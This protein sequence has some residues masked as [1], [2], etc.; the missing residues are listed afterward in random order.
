MKRKFIFLLTMM[1]LTLLG[2]AKWNV[3][4]AQS[5][6]VEIGENSSTTNANIPFNTYYYASI[7]QQIYLSNQINGAG[8]IADV[9]F[10]RFSGTNQAREIEVYMVNTSKTQFDHSSDWVAVTESDRV[11]NG[12]LPYNGTA[13]GWYTITLDNPFEYTGE[14]LLIC[15][16]LKN[17]SKWDYTNYHYTID[18][19]NTLA[20][21]KYAD[22]ST[23]NPSNMT[24]SGTLLN[25][26]NQVRF[27]IEPSNDDLEPA[28][29][30]NLVATAKNHTSI[31]LAWDA[32]ENVKSYN[33]YQDGVKLANVTSTYYLVEGL[34]EK[35]DYCFT[36]TGVR[37]S[38]ESDASGEA[39]AK[40]NAA[41]LLR[42]VIVG[43][44]EGTCNFI[45]THTYYKYAITQQI[46][47]A[48]ELGFAAG[49]ISK[50]AFKNV[51]SFYTARNIDV[52]IV[53]TTKDSFVDKNDVVQMTDADLV[54]SGTH[55]FGLG[56]S[57][58]VFSKNFEYTGGNILI[59]VDDNTGN[60]PGT[61]QFAT[62]THSNSNNRT[63][64][65]YNDGGNYD[66][67]TITSLTYAEPQ[68]NQIK[69]FVESQPSLNVNVDKIE[70]P[71]VRLG[72]YWTGK[73]TNMDVEVRTEAIG[74]EVIDIETTNNYFVLS[75]IDLSS[76]PIIFNVSCSTDK[77]YEGEQNGN[78]IISY[79]YEGDSE[80]LTKEI[81]MS[82]TAYAPATP[83]VY[84]LAQEVT[85]TN[86]SYTNTPNFA[87]LHDDYILPGEVTEGN[88]LDAVY[89]FTMENEGALTVNV[90]GTN[91]I[92]AIY[93]AEDLQTNGPSFNNNYEGTEV[94]V[95]PSAPTSF[96][97][98]FEDGSLED[99]N[100][101]EYDGN[102]NHW[103][104]TTSNGINCIVSYSYLYQAGGNIM[105]ADNYIYTKEKYA[106]T[107]NSKLSFDTKILST[108]YPDKVM[109]K[110]STDGEVFTLIETI[111]PMSLEWVSKTVDLGAK[112][113]ELGLAYGEYHIALHHQDY[114]QERIYIDNLR[115][116]D[117]SA[118]NRGAQIDAV[119]YPAG[120]YYLVAAAEDEF[121]VS[122]STEALP[123]PEALTEMTP[124]NGATEQDNPK[125]TWSFGKYTSEYQV[126]L[127]TTNP[128]TEVVVDWT[129]E[130]ATS[131]QTEGLANQTIYYWQV[132]TRNTIGTTTGEVYSFSTPLNKATELAVTDAELY[133]GETTTLT[134]TAA[135]SA[136]SYNVYVNE[137]LFAEAIE[138][139]SF[140]LTNLPHNVNPGNAITVTAVHTLGESAHSEAV[141][142]KMAGT[143]N[144]VVNVKD[145]EGNV[146]ENAAVAFNTINYYDEYY[147][148]VPAID[149]LYTD[150]DGKATQT[151]A[152][153]CE[154][155][156]PNWTYA[157]LAVNISKEYANV[158]YFYIN[159]NEV[160]NG[161]VYV[162]DITLE[163]VGP[164]YVE[165]DKGIYVAGE[166]MMVLTWNKV[167]G[168]IAYNIYKQG[169]YSYETYEYEYTLI[170]TETITDT[171]FTV[172]SL[173][174]VP[175]SY[176]A[177]Y[178]VSA[179]YSFGE[180]AKTDKWVEITGKGLISGTV[181]DG[182]N[183]IEGAVVAIS[184]Y[185]EYSGVSRNYTTTTA[186]DG[187]Y[188]IN[189]LV[190]EYDLTV[191]RYD[192][193]DYSYSGIES[194]YGTPTVLDIVLEQ[195]AVVEF[196][197]T[198]V[199]SGEYVNVS[200]T[201]PENA[202]SYK[203]YR[204]DSEGNVTRIYSDVTSLTATDYNWSTLENGTYEY[205]VSA[206]IEV[207]KS[208]TEGFENGGN[209]PDGWTTYHTGT[210]STFDWT[211]TT[212]A[213]NVSPTEGSY[214]VY[215]NNTNGSGSSTYG[216]FYLVAPLYDL[217]GIENPVVSFY[218]H[219]P[220]YSA[221]YSGTNYTNKL[222][223]LV[224]TE[225]ATGPW[226]EVWNNERGHTTGWT[227][228]AADLTAYK[229]QQVYI[230]FCTDVKYGRCSAID[231]VVFPSIS[232]SSESKI[233]WSA[234]IQKKA[235][236]EFTAA[237]DNDWNNPNNWSTGVVPTG[238]NVLI[239]ANAEV[240]SEADVENLKLQS[241]CSLTVKNGGALTVTGTITNNGSIV[242]ND[243]GQIF[244]SNENVYVTYNMNI[245]NPTTWGVS[246]DGWQFIASPFNGSSIINFTGFSW[247]PKSYDLYKYDGT[248]EGAE[249]NNHKDGGF[250]EAFVNGRGYLA[251]YETLTTATLSGYL[252]NKD[253][254]NFTEVTYTAGEGNGLANFH[255]LGNPFPFNMDWS[256]VA[257]ENVYPAFA[258]VDPST[259]GY[260]KSIESG[261]TTIPVG[262]GFFV[263][264]IA[265]DPS[266]SYGT[267]SK[268][269][270]EKYEY[271]NVIASG[272]QGSNNVIIKLAGKEEKGFSKLENLNQS[273]ADIYVKNNGR[274]YSVLGYDRDVTEIELFF[275]AKEMG[276][277]NISIEPNGKFQNVTLVDRKTGA[278]TNMLL[279]SYSFTATANE[280]PDRFFIRLDNG[281]S[282][283]DGNFV[284]QSGDE[285]IVEAEGTIQII[286]VMGRMV[287]NNDVESSNNRINVSNLKGA[288][289]IVRNI[290]ENVVRTQKI[291]I[292]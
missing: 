185:N 72:N 62:N 274:Q 226:T 33:V 270:G 285:L 38:K 228:N 43:N 58:I 107:A 284:Y 5:N 202:T 68:N 106:I 97:Y 87:T 283:I 275:D 79:N 199:E 231:Y 84:E 112:F 236:I 70:F 266:I 261:I 29:P 15:I 34:E 50:I 279:D 241:G 276:N 177:A 168:A 111:D 69:F 104:S 42:E 277:Y 233:N 103:Q 6:V 48:E 160:S 27:T 95:T 230:A 102:N 11:F 35:T 89:H 142:V 2:G 225:S 211:P 232:I 122:I 60:Y 82:A 163:Y 219:T 249:W 49:N 181:T 55:T 77:Q 200:W 256:N 182:T 32:A 273:I 265:D 156:D 205:G 67:K 30:T 116:S 183:P 123:A 184:Y 227:W 257:L 157:S 153:L 37:G 221:S 223:V 278:E 138:G 146:I 99:F 135:E 269:R 119:Q 133:P 286:D 73:A 118:K 162:K 204:R 4:N 165:T 71:L 7:T 267:A 24:A 242:L 88:T 147:Q 290:S 212:Y 188:E 31:E 143:F 151:L 91:A 18:T 159:S 167:E 39:C 120:T 19:D 22:G 78:L 208:Y 136:I 187:S 25:K 209:L 180:S 238:E 131:F 217:T 220:Q 194:V 126:L 51:G 280:N 282:A 128:P 141:N 23:Y 240:S 117:G 47:T 166:D 52:Y 61:V 176:F 247:A 253:Y 229:N 224:S 252:Y 201:A 9:S 214:A 260:V 271:I 259:G 186:A 246:E 264:A 20:L 150:A 175:G 12:T 292:L 127:G 206:C 198:A 144:L 83:D 57:E 216:E 108:Q 54:Y 40:T 98:D 110:V 262:D 21:Y 65:Y 76:N 81:P 222:S 218:Y 190:G 85:F 171:T 250:E 203:V 192:Y 129:S 155:G 17:T 178:A 46:Y 161:E 170:N 172:E 195:N 63:I 75:E 215:S 291:V 132:N 26:Q 289:Y 124:A 245:V 96:F 255:L 193:K 113:A 154:Y 115:L 56:W 210:S 125:L 80:T 237:E 74:V 179:V 239:S 258:T 86:G 137:V 248:A 196:D 16:N 288:T 213:Y 287:Y 92:A 41:P 148:L 254:F 109:V 101:V 207:N 14:N 244:Q 90:T 158:A 191:T 130:L 174:Y 281:Q 235:S 94:E 189:A 121:T 13:N 66:P 3:L 268:S 272:R 164:E 169:E 134:W 8:T 234:P 28:V 45:P 36:V 10:K 243:G 59:C 139:T 114:Y 251:S 173:E 145:T 44:G 197:V 140:E 149:T 1:F 263:E 93:K 64:G 53:N 152:L 105:N 100:L